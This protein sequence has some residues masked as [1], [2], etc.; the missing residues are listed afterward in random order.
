MCAPQAYPY[1]QGKRVVKIAQ[2]PDGSPGTVT[3][4]LGDCTYAPPNFGASAYSSPLGE[5]PYAGLSSILPVGDGSTIYFVGYPNRR[6][7]IVNGTVYSVSFASN[8]CR[9]AP[10]ITYNPINNKLYRSNVNCGIDEKHHSAYI[11]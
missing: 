11:H 6:W 5:V 2:N 1:N 4:V 10:Y 8:E 3:R 7:K 9:S